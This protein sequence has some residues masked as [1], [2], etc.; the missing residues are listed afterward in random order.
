MLFA[1]VF[2]LPGEASAQTMEEWDI[3]IGID[4]GLWSARMR[5]SIVGDEA[6]SD[7]DTIDFEDDLDI[8]PTERV[9]MGTA[10]IDFW[11]NR[12]QIGHWSIDYK[13]TETLEQTF[14]F[15][16]VTFPVF[17][18]V[19]SN[20]DLQQTQLLYGRTIV[21]DGSAGALYRFDAMLGLHHYTLDA[22]IED[23]AGPSSASVNESLLLPVV[24]IYG[25]IDVFYSRDFQIWVDGW[26]SGIS[27][28]TGA[29]NGNLFDGHLEAVF[30]WRESASIALGY[31]LFALDAS[32][33]DNGGD[34]EIDLNMQG[35]TLTLSLRY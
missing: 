7:G 28:G 11:D 33:D 29:G 34:D 27:L 16:G 13:G 23:V 4:A 3:G 15:D 26:A 35:L 24:G 30:A 8:D 31:R 9:W 20:F 5:G 21:R 25:Q 2:A 32:F 12:V 18:R 10:W 17:T 6:N 1:A 19:D 14:V 22:K